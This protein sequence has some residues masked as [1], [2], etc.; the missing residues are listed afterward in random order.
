MV[1]ATAFACGLVSGCA[2]SGPSQAGTELSLEEAGA[3]Y[4]EIVEPTNVLLEELDEAILAG[5]GAEVRSVADEL[6]DGYEEMAA[7]LRSVAWP[8]DPERFA[9]EL[10]DEVED[11]APYWAA[12]AAGDD[13][14]TTA[15][16]IAALPE[17]SRAADHLRTT[18]G[19]AERAP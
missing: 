13:D 10:A 3:T 14:A 16:A 7:E 12:V 4:L 9:L 15:D 5:D 19:L 17:V 18:L 11:E 2:P 6:A 8:E 1:A